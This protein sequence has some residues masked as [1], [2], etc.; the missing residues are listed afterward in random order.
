MF[1]FDLFVAVSDLTYTE[2]GSF[3]C[4]CKNALVRLI[5]DEPDVEELD[6]SIAILDVY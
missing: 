6:E 1:L 2:V 4:D 5:M 3:F